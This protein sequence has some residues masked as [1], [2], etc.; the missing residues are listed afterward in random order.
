MIDIR[1]LT[2]GS[3]VEFEGKLHKVMEVR[4]DGSVTI[5]RYTN[6]HGECMPTEG[7][8]VKGGI[9]KCR[10]IIKNYSCSDIQPVAI[11]PDLL[12]ELG[13]KFRKS[14]GGSWCISDKKGGYFY[15]TVCSDSTCIVTHY[16][17]F[18][19][20]SRVVCAYLHELE[21]F[22]CLISKTELIPD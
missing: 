19:F 9:Y 18:G 10:Y 6:F 7:A 21:A 16:P 11:T 3:H 14:A 15:A 1:Q 12:K 2:I 20:Q 17:D 22:A 4:S 13:V 5:G 8:K